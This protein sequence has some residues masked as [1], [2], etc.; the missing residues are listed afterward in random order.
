MGS[1]LVSGN[2]HADLINETKPLPRLL[3]GIRTLSSCWIEI[4][5]V[6]L[7]SGINLN[8]YQTGKIKNQFLHKG[9]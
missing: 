1:S 8:H 5:W 6:V 4:I 2:K 3:E 9:L 7:K